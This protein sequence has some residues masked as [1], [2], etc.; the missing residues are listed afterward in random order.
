[1]LSSMVRIMFKTS[2]LEP[3]SLYPF[4]CQQNYHREDFL[5]V[6][7][8][9]SL[10]KLLFYWNV[11]H[12]IL[13][14][15]FLQDLYA[16]MLQEGKFWNTRCMLFYNLDHLLS[17]WR[18]D[19]FCSPSC[20]FTIDWLISRQQ[21]HE[22]VLVWTFGWMHSLIQRRCVASLSFSPSLL[23]ALLR[24]LPPAHSMS[25]AKIWNAGFGLAS[26]PNMW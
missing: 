15:A 13:P 10:F 22:P 5:S 14:P 7:A 12:V 25:V 19:T 1:M 26:G 23:L 17:C 21:V 8:A 11:P 9:S 4:M 3:Y 24:C 20:V 16:N 18:V 2:F 6:I